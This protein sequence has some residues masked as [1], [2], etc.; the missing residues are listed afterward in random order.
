MSIAKI[1]SI[2]AIL[3]PFQIHLLY[4][5]SY[6]LTDDAG[7]FVRQTALRL[8]DSVTIGF[9]EELGGITLCEFAVAGVYMH[10]LDNAMRR[11]IEV[12]A[13]NKDII[14]LRNTAPPCVFYCDANSP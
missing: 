7:L 4:V 9:D 8:N 14:I 10:R 6:K 11:E 1:E 12:I 13:A 5:V 2:I 3:A